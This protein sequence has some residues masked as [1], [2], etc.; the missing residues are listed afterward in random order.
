MRFGANTLIWAMS[1]GPEH[2]DLLPRIKEAGLDGVETPIFDPPSYPAAAIRRELAKN[3]LAL[4]ACTVMP[5]GVSLGDPDPAVRRRGCE[6]IASC[7]KAAADA[8]VELL[9][10]P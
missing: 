9:V 4:T 5:R 3:Q 1:F 2:F 6:H 10:G 8:G 7:M